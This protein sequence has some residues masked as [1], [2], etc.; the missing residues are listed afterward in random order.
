MFRFEEAEMKAQI[1]PKSRRQ[2]IKNLG[3]GMLVAGLGASLATEIG[4]AT[5]FVSQETRDEGYG[6]LTKLVRM[7]Q[8]MHPDK[9]QQALVADF[10]SGTTSLKDSIAAAALANAETFGGTDYVGYHAEMALIPALEMTQELP[11]EKSALPVLKVLYRNSERIQKVGGAKARA[12]RPVKETDDNRDTNFGPRLKQLVRQA[13]M[14]KAEQLFAS[15]VK[16]SAGDVKKMFNYL[17]HTIEDEIDVHRFVLAYRAHGLIDL[18]GDDRAHMMLRQCVR[19]CV[20]TEKKRISKGRSASPIRTHLPKMLD[21]YKLLEK[22]L[23]DRD[24]GDE[25]VA[26]MCESIY[27]SDKFEAAELAAAALA[28]GISPEVVGEAISLAANQLVLRQG[29]DPWRTHGASA[30]VHGSD[31][32]NAWRNI[33]RVADSRNQITGLIVAAFHTGRYQ[34]FKGKAYPTD[35]HVGR[36]KATSAKELLGTAEEAIT[37]ND[38]ALAAAAIQVY[39]DQKHDPRQ[40]FD[41]MLKYAIS[42]DGR[43]H[44]EKYYRTVCEEYQTIRPAFRWRQLVSLARVT[45]SAYGYDVADNKGHRAPGFDDACKQ[46]GVEL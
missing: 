39:G 15:A 32:V 11:K 33:A 36:I 35:E 17:L 45:A 3:G 22:K 25:W 23:G 13:D 42:E 41:L 43:L 5:E 37:S 7:M 20:D 1:V 19:H 34:P 2:F 6:D 27:G 16:G 24:P 8:E 29:K 10:K 40:V 26:E 12:L 14:V 18:V 4:C 9:L 28:D 30:G 21:Q 31:A 38:Q 46:L 44:S